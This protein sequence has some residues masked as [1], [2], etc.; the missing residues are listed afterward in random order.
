MKHLQIIK[1]YFQ[2]LPVKNVYLFGS[3]ANN[4]QTESSDIDLIVDVDYSQ[5]Q[6]S[7]LDFIGWKLDLEKLVGKKIDLVSEDGVSK[8]IRPFIDKEKTLLYEKSAG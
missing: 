1:N 7:L 3:Y 2:N 6:V 5:K 4:T 8:Y